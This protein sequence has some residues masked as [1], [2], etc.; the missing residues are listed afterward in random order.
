MLIYELKIGLEVQ[1]Y[2]NVF[3][4][5]LGQVIIALGLYSLGLV[6]VGFR[7]ALPFAIEFL[8]CWSLGCVVI[9][10]ASR[11]SFWEYS[12]VFSALL[13][14]LGAGFVYY[15]NPYGKLLAVVAVGGFIAAM[16]F[17]PR[18]HDLKP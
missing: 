8:G 16:I 4:V 12:G 3:G 5:A 17:L 18:R 14:L 10:W 6:V 2:R 9:A 7:R 15:H 1:M 11:L 13:T